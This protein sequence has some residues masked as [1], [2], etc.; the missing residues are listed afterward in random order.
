MRVLRRLF[1]P[2]IA[3]LALWCLF[4]TA[5]VKSWLPRTS[6]VFS[7]PV[8]WALYAALPVGFFLSLILSNDADARPGRALLWTLVATVVWGFVSWTILMNFHLAIGGKL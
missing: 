5:Y 6:A 4:D 8:W 7:G 3:T 1:L 2:G